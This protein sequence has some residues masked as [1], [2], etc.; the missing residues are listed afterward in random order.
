VE[1]TDIG[2][3]VRQ[4]EVAHSGLH[5]SRR[6]DEMTQADVSVA[7][8]QDAACLPVLGSLR[9]F[10]HEV[11][12]WRDHDN[13][14]VGPFIDPSYSYEGMSL[15]ARDL[16][17]WFER[18]I[19][20]FDRTFIATDLADIATTYINDA[21]SPDPSPNISFL[22]APTGVLGSRSVAAAT[23]RRAADELR[24]LARTGL[25]WSMV[26]RTFRLGGEE[27]P[28]SNLVTLTED[29][30]EI[31]EARMDGLSFANEV[32]VLGASGS[33]VSTPVRGSASD[34]TPSPLVQQTFAEASILDF[35]S[36]NH[37]AQTR[38][39]LLR[40]DPWFVTGTLLPSAPLSFSDL[41][42]GARVRLLQQVGFRRLD[43]DLRLLAVTVDVSVSDTGDE[44]S[45]RLELQP[46]GTVE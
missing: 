27:I 36:A 34:G 43:V 18:R 32:F 16:F 29:I 37:A 45:I 20:P 1:I 30:F 8:G 14:W 23:F 15:M 12:I 10:H 38:L 21:L 46:L 41:V 7:A 11:S 3:A 4:A 25:D 31:D 19:L 42:P 44:E 5:Y 13:V 9:P 35:S 33:G 2:G 28:T 40:T 22:A 24:E 6:L 26:G 39:D 17:Q